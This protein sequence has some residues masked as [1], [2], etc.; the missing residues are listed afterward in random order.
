M[1][2]EIEKKFLIASNAWQKNI[3]RTINIKQG[4]LNTDP[5]RTV[6][7]RV[8]GE[9]AWL[10]VKGRNTGITRLEYE[11]EIPLMEAIELV[12]LCEQP[13]IEKTRYLVVEY[14]K[15]W[16]VDVFSGANEGLTVAEI[17]LETE[18]EAFTLP[19]WIGT[20]VSAD[21]RYYNASL[22]R[23]PFAEW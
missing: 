22:I 4:Y 9:K 10:T 23:K 15:T 14:G 20:E 3:A 17:E 19:A 1:P 6:R 11:Y 12:G 18:D 7:V 16:E 8:T 21:P 5:D 13:V 2:K